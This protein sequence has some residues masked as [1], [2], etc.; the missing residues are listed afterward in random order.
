MIDLYLIRHAESE[1]NV[2]EDVRVTGQ[3]PGLLLTERGERQAALLAESFLQRGVCFDEMYSSTAVRASE[4]AK[5]IANSAGFRLENIDYSSDLLEL[6]QGDWEGK[7]RDEVYTPEVMHKMRQNYWNFKAPHGE[8]Q[9]DLE[10][11][12][13]GFFWDTFGDDIKDERHVSAAVVSHHMAI[14]C[15]L[16]GVYYWKPEMTF[17]TRIGNTGVTH[18]RYDRNG[19]NVLCMNDTAH[20]R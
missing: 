9:C 2:G 1:G 13:H 7:L 8:S 18:V 6:S 3:S 11:R 15:F 5:I 17:N 19:W 14:K 20:L 4:T 12:M 10:K 16:R